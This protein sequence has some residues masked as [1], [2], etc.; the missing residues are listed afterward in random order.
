MAEGLKYDTP[1]ELR[2]YSVTISEGPASLSVYEKCD[3]GCDE[4]VVS[5]KL[6]SI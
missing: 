2:S 1:V 6:Q 3:D 5:P 4:G